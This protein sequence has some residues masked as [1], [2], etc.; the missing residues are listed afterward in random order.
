MLSDT[1]LLW[2]KDT[3]LT[4]SSQLPLQLGLAMWLSSC[5]CKI[6]TQKTGMLL[7]ICPPPK[8]FHVTFHIMSFT[9]YGV[10]VALLMNSEPLTMA[11]PHHGKI[12]LLT[13]SL[14]YSICHIKV[15][16]TEPQQQKHLMGLR[17]RN[18]TEGLDGLAPGSKEKG[19]TSG[20]PAS[21]SVCVA[22]L[23]V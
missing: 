9:Y 5:Q 4:C 11:E 21:L 17:A 23:C 2:L 10:T 22:F 7:H 13:D 3:Q 15:L 1:C 6:C 12:T 16:W 14:I 8:E 18:L 19:Y 20:F